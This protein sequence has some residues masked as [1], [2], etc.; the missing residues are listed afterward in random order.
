MKKLEFGLA[1]IALHSGIACIL[2]HLLACAKHKESWSRAKAGMLRE[3]SKPFKI[4]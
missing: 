4:Y 3:L 1:M 2:L